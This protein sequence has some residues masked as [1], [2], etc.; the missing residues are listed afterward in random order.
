MTDQQQEKIKAIEADRRKALPPVFLTGEEHEA[1]A[2]NVTTHHIGTYGQ[3]NQALTT[4]QRAG[5]Q[6]MIGA[7]HRGQVKAATRRGGINITTELPS[8]SLWTY[9][10]LFAR[11]KPLFDELKLT[12]E[13]AK[14][15]AE[16]LPGQV[17]G[18]RGTGAD[19][20]RS[21]QEQGRAVEKQLATFLTPEQ[22]KRYRQILL[23]QLDG[24]PGG[25]G[26]ALSPAIVARIVEVGAEL[27][28][29]AAQK[30]RLSNQEPLQ[31]VL[32]ADQKV[33]WTAMTGPR[34][35]GDLSPDILGGG[36]R[37]GRRG[38]APTHET[39]QYL[40]QKS[41][42]DDAKLTASQRAKLPEL[43]KTW[44]APF[45]NFAGTAAERQRL[46]ADGRQ[47]MDK[48]LDAMLDAKQRTRVQQIELQQYEKAGMSDLLT[49][50][51]VVKELAQTED[52]QKKLTAVDSDALKTRLLMSAELPPTLA[53]KTR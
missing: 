21:V 5:L 12:E 3:L 22:V 33:M 13:Q 42:Q 48:A 49:E 7:P 46:L 10:T 17:G 53:Q 40:Q 43:E 24:Q 20:E 52:Q 29:D 14:R 31:A 8:L 2:R 28:L 25:G 32:N 38:G 51:R 26:F 6:D 19:A 34:F 44:Q 36:G 41:V 47:A 35:A 50:P 11:N 45:Q 30:N 37:G 9:M 4:D 23:Q 16:F 27:K 18:L 39:L 1:I 15:L